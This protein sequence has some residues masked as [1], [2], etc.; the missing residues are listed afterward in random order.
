ML[1]AGCSSPYDPTAI[2]L[3]HGHSDHVANLPFHCYGVAPVQIYAPHEIVPFA[4]A[5]E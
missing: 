3:T 1:D 5:L 2:L 4:Q